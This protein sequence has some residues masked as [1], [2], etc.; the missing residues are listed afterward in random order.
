MTSIKVLS[1]WSE[2]LVLGLR[3][4]YAFDFPQP[5]D[6]F[7]QVKY[8]SFAIIPFHSIHSFVLLCVP[9]YS[10]NITIQSLL[11]TIIHIACKDFFRAVLD[12]H[13]N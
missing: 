8:N 6:E 12:S 5:V 1:P 10:R 13:Q 7:I 3:I 4:A 9:V 11:Y 2:Y